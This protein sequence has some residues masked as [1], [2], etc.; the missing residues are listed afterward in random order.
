MLA[1]Y[2]RDFDTVELNTTFYRLP[3]EE[4]VR[5]WRAQTPRNFLFAAKGSRFITHMKKLKDPVEA[6]ARYFER[7]QH[8]GP[9]LGPIVFQLPPFWKRNRERLAEFLAVLPSEYRYAFELREP[10][11][12]HDEVYD[13]LRQYNVA[14]CLFDIRKFETPEIITADF[15]YV[16]LHGPSEQAYQGSYDEAT[17]KRWARSIRR[18]QKT[19]TGIYV[20]FDNDQAGYAVQDALRLKKMLRMGG[21]GAAPALK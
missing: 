5:Q 21:A 9:K 2:L 7:I 19:L 16:R 12:H 13:L 8:L 6:V 14:V 1:L 4:S 10:S 20:Y 3:D 18:W 11:W 17:L 15:V